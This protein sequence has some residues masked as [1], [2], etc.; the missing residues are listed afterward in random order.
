MSCVFLCPGCLTSTVG[1]GRHHSAPAWCPSSVFRRSLGYCATVVG[2]LDLL[3]TLNVRQ[4]ARVH[5]GET[6]NTGATWPLRRHGNA[7]YHVQRCQVSV[8]LSPLWHRRWIF[9]NIHVYKP[10]GCFWLFKGMHVT[11]SNEMQV[12]CCAHTYAHKK[13]SQTIGCFCIDFWVDDFKK[14]KG[15]NAFPLVLLSIYFPAKKKGGE[16]DFTWHISGPGLVVD[17]AHMRSC[18]AR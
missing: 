6:P 3:E 9:H 8:F 1:V 11:I 2:L 12:L 15:G 4:R 5:F 18:V 7:H 17:I 14:T 13:K 10:A 16:L